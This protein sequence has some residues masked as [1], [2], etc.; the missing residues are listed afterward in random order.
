SRH[1]A[2]VRFKNVMTFIVKKSPFTDDEVRRLQSA[3]DDLGFTL[4]YAPGAAPPAKVVEPPEMV[5]IGTSTADY[6]K[7]ILASGRA[8]FLA[9]YPLDVG[10]TTD[11]PPFFF[12]TTRLRDQF[13]SGFGFSMLFANGLSALMMLF[14]ISVVLVVAF[15]IGPLFVGGARPARGWGP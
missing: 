14:G 10:A 3:A 15:I 7:L 9:D 1:L 13:A 2:V 5:Q 12:H 4:L 11:A 8:R 6:R